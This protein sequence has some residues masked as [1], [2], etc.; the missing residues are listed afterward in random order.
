[1][2]KVLVTGGTKGIGLEITKIF[3]ENNFDAIVLGRDFSSFPKNLKVK[4]VKFDLSSIKDIP[5]LAKEIGDIDIL[6]NNAGLMNA[7]PYNDYPEN[8]KEEIVKINLE[9][10]IGLITEFSKGMI[11]KGGGRIVSI[12]AAFGAR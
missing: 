3:L 5:E 10:P 6:V 9:A 1:M 12:G 4:Q 7:I 11:K 2:K 8:K